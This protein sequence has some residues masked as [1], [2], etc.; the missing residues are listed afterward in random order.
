MGVLSAELRKLRGDA[1]GETGATKRATEEGRS[2][3]GCNNEE[4]EEEEDR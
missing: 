2:L 3:G 4:E 1:G